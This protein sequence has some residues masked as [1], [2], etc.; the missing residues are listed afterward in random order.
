MSDLSVSPQDTW[1]NG[2]A[3]DRYV[4][5]WSRRVARDFLQWLAIPN[6]SDWLDVGCGTGTLVRTI[7]ETG[8]PRSIKGVDQSESFVGHARATIRDERAR[9]EVG[10][11]QALPEQTASYDVAVS[12]LVLNFVPEPRLAASEMSRVTRP[13]GVVAVYV[14]DYAGRM[15]LMRHFWDAAAALDPDGRAMDE[16]PRFPICQPKPLTELLQNAG[17][18]NVAIRA[19]E[20]RTDFKDFDDYWSPFLGGQGPAPRYAMSLSEERRAE[21]REKIRAGLPFAPDGSIPLLARAWAAR[22]ERPLEP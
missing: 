18:E 2:A 8:A 12:G 9:F 11:A 13:G 15:D 4:G 10:E 7:L 6:G 17:L 19:I 21:L 3:Y 1:A 16:A 14:W 20:I 5:R 22:G